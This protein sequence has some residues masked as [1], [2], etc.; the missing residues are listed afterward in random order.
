MPFV[1]DTVVIGAGHAENEPEDPKI[2]QLDASLQ[3]QGAQLG[4]SHQPHAVQPDPKCKQNGTFDPPKE[5]K[6]KPEPSKGV[7]AKKIPFSQLFIPKLRLLKTLFEIDPLGGWLLIMSVLSNG[8]AKI[9]T[10]S[11][12]CQAVTMFQTALLARSVH[13]AQIIPLLV[14]QLVFELVLQSSIYIGEYAMKR[15]KKKLTKRLTEDLLE[16]FGHFPYATRI[17][18]YMLKR[19]GLVNPRLF[20][21]DR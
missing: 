11:Y 15:Y 17:D 8:F 2:Q 10:L 12:K 16:A 7:K 20:L 9:W 14:Q 6:S 5:M 19:H 18:R 3:V 4:M 13:P 21:A 1:G